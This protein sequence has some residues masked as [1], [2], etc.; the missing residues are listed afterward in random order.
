MKIE[1]CIRYLKHPNVDDETGFVLREDAL[2]DLKS[3]KRYPVGNNMIDFQGGVKEHARQKKSG[4]WFK[5]NMYYSDHFDPWIRNSIFTSGGLGFVRVSSKMKQW[6]DKFVSGDVLFIEPEDKRLVSY[7]GEDKCLVLGDF[8]AKNYLPPEKDYPNLNASPE[9]MPILSGSFHNI[10]SSF[11]LEHV[12]YPRR[13]MKELERIL[14]PGGYILLGGPGD[15][16]PS[17]RTPFNYFNVIRYGYLEMFSEN[18]LELVEEY[19]PARSWLSIL[20][21][22]NM[23][24]LRNDWFN[25]NQVTKFLQMGILAISLVI[26]PLLN[27]LAYLLDLVT[28]FDK[29]VYSMY[30][31]LLRKPV[32][33]STEAETGINLE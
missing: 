29:R 2:I 11:V 24:T 13:H 23:V 30:I 25:K 4:L 8:T 15:I 27:F 10:I 1:D 21:L 3:G 33:R 22:F 17:H 6:I 19:Y 16:Y 14:K 26:S 28:P 5:L 7:I 18:N 32:A 31:A 9:Q 12:K 20:Y